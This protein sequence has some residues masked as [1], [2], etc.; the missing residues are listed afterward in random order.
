MHCIFH[1]ET[2][3]AE[4]DLYVCCPEPPMHSKSEPEKGQNHGSG[5]TDR[6]LTRISVY[7]KAT[8][9][10]FVLP[11]IHPFT[12]NAGVVKSQGSGLRQP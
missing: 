9:L 10:S 1:P 11:F 12:A 4:N 6:R 7:S 3:T 5:N 2:D 8:Y